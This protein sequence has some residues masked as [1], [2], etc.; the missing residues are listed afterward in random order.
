MWTHII[1]ARAAAIILALI[2]TAGHA[3]E[4]TFYF[5][6]NGGNCLGCEWIEASGEITADTPARFTAFADSLDGGGSLA[7]DSTG[8]DPVAAMALG[9]L[10]RDRGWGTD[11]R[12]LGTP[13]GAEPARDTICKD[14]CI[15]AFMGGD[16]RDIDPSLSVTITGE[17]PVSWISTEVLEYTLEMG[18]SAEVLTIAARVAQG[19]TY[20]FDAADHERLGLDSTA[21][22]TD[23]WHL[24]PYKDGLVLATKQR[25][26]PSVE[27]PFTLFCR[28][29]D[30]RLHLLVV[31][32]GD[33]SNITYPGDTVLNVSSGEF[34]PRFILDGERYP[35]GPDDVEFVRQGE[36]NLTASIRLPEALGI[37][38]GE[39][40]SFTP[41]L[42]RVFGPVLQFSLPLPPENWITAV[43]Q[44]CI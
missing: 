36:T 8:G 27:Q 35:L 29:E 9:R 1:Q 17:G 6:G 38:G 26:G 20:D 43:R 11:R 42:G 24:E 33:F 30:P 13:S 21:L 12:E 2:A 41:N 10:I 34:G 18:V 4:M 39:D 19:Q 25:Y 5:T 28:A 22:V 40:L 15:L 3:Q 14:A 23:D 44:N 31:E 37:T 16:N 32:P 7:F